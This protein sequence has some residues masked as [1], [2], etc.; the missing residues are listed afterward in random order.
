MVPCRLN[1]FSS[2]SSLK[3]LYREVYENQKT[4]FYCIFTLRAPYVAFSF[5]VM[6][7]LY[8]S[9][10]IVNS[11]EMRGNCELVFLGV[12]WILVLESKV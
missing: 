7:D 6:D 5:Q 3:I 4:N 2:G 8:D 11:N 9:I 10:R 12:L 1:R